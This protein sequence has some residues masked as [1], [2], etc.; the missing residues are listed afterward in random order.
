MSGIQSVHLV[1]IGLYA[2][3]EVRVTAEDGERVNMVSLAAD[4]PSVYVR[5]CVSR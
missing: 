2:A 1:P 5:V 3:D 4:M